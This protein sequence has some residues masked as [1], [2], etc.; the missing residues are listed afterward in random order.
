VTVQ[1]RS[2][3]IPTPAA[4]RV[5]VLVAAHPKFWTFVRLC[6][7]SILS[8]GP[9]PPLAHYPA[10]IVCLATTLFKKVAQQVKNSVS[11]LQLLRT[12]TCPGFFFRKNSRIIIPQA[13]HQ[14]L[15]TCFHVGFLRF[16]LSLCNYSRSP[17]KCIYSF[18]LPYSWERQR[19]NGVLGLGLER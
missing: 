19:G 12:C 11:L 15:V 2:L 4:L 6:A 5:L 10:F 3:W 17:S 8:L 1:Q 13:A 14:A 9:K 16:T 7:W 18:L